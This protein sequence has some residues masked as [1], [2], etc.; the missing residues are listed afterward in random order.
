MNV[1]RVVLEWSTWYGAVTMSILWD[2]A[3]GIPEALRATLD[4][5]HGF[6]GALESLSRAHVR[7]IVATGNG[8]SYYAAMAL[9]L[10]SLQ[11][12]G[13]DVV[14]LP[15]GVVASS[16]F[17]WRKGDVLLAISSSGEF[18]DVVL[19]AQNGAPA[20]AITANAGS[21]LAQRAKTAAMA[22]LPA[23]RSVTHTQA[24]CASVLVALT[25]W[26][27]LAED[28][29]LRQALERAP[30]LVSRA[31]EAAGPWA[32]AQA[33][34]VRNPRAAVVFG[35]GPAWAAA[36]ET[37]LLLK[38]VAQIPAEG[39]ETREGAT[40][41]MYAL[42]PGHLAVSV[43][44]GDDALLDEAESVCQS[45]GATVI[46][47]PGGELGD[48]R[49]ASLLSFPAALAL[50]IALAEQAGVDV[51]APPWVSAY[52]RTSRPPS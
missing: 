8:A 34:R 52:E 6:D 14:A 38:E 30:D 1:V 49:C 23:Q 5:R 48:P 51:D 7:R 46:R 9:W 27:Q 25:L 44:C 26:S 31:L 11:A 10:A 19:A 50:T 2:E 45:A 43:R 20:V 18:R 36:L 24:Y 47:L 22:Q 42:G 15:S 39:V 13:P 28:A 37:A 41:A 16:T 35:S 32:A 21:S 40:S 4:G 3:C 17:G 33:L 12:S 29:G